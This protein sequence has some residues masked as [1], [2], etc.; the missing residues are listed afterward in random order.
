MCCGI[1]GNEKALPAPGFPT[2][3]FYVVEKP[4]NRRNHTGT[5]LDGLVIIAPTRTR[6]RSVA[7]A[8]GHQRIVLK[9]FPRLAEVFH[10]HIGVTD[11]TIS[12]DTCGVA[13]ASVADTADC[14]DHGLQQLFRDGCGN[15]VL[16]IKKDCS[17]CAPCLRNGRR[18]NGQKE[19]C[20]QKVR[21]IDKYTIHSSRIIKPAMNSK[22]ACSL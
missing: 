3:W 20:L 10:S 8:K 14:V 4:K 16:C 9:D 2:G 12:A 17:K 13:Y 15:C 5:V 7:S 22:I 21:A 19:V 18:P 6:Y 1:A 11:E